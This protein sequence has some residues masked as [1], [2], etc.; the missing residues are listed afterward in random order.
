M[1]APSQ[2]A[3]QHTPSAQKP[4]SQTRQPSTL[5]SLPGAALQVLPSGLRATHVPSGAQY[6]LESQSASI[7][8]LTHD[9]S[10]PLHVSAPQDGKPGEPAEYVVQTP[11]ADAPAATEQASQVPVQGLSQQMPSAQLPEPH[12]EFDVHESLVAE[13]SRSTCTPVA[14]GFK[15]ET[16]P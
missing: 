9:V 7:T 11:S 15:P 6:L 8:Q 2:G 5:Q 3:L 13:P 12:S 4:V 14:Q 1:Q 16:D 10:V